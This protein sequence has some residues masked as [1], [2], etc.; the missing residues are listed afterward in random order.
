MIVGIAQSTRITGHPPIFWDLTPLPKSIDTEL[1]V[2]H[3]DLY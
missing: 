1:G 2:Q 3:K